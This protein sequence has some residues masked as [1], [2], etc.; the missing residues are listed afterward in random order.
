MEE[1]FRRSMMPAYEQFIKVL[2]TSFGANS[3]TG[4]DLWRLEMEVTKAV[5]VM[6]LQAL[7][8]LIELAHGRGYEGSQRE[9]GNCGG[10]MK[11]ES[12]RERRLLAVSARSAT[13]ATTTTAVIV[14]TAQFP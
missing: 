1:N 3:S 7:W 11:F 12:Y 14:A 2:S 9:C 13:S 4:C 8:L 6:A 5:A 10:R